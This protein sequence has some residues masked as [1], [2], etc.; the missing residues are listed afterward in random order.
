MG[1]PWPLFQLFLFFLYSN[2]EKHLGGS[3][4]QARIFGEACE[5]VYH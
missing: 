5:G 3:V 2:K 1:Q 4:I